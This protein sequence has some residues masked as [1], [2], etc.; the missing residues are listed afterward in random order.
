MKCFSH[1]TT[2]AIASCKHCFKGV[3]EACAIDTGNGV[4]CSSACSDQLGQMAA[5]VKTSIAAARINQGSAAFLWP[6]FVGVL[7]LAFVVES[8]FSRRASSFGL[9]TGLL[10]VLFGVVLGVVQYVW[11]KRSRPD[12]AA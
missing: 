5:L 1:R 12:S 10:F 2:D 3:C 8:W 7:G 4:A 11:R 6:V 9:L